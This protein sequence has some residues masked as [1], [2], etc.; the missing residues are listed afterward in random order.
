MAE[1]GMLYRVET[2]NHHLARHG[3]V[4]KIIG[5]SVYQ[6]EPVRYIE[7]QG[8]LAVATDGLHPRR[9]LDPGECLW[10]VLANRIQVSPEY[11]HARMQAAEKHRAA[12][13]RY[14]AEQASAEVHEAAK[15]VEDKTHIA[16]RFANSPGAAP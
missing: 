15:H 13:R 3:F 16:I 2:A 11:M 6:C 14:Q 4:T 5:R 10:D 9:T 12:E 7:T 8:C 1:A